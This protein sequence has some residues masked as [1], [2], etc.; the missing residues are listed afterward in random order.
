MR[1]DEIKVKFFILLACIH[2]QRFQPLVRNI[3]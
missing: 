1:T 2:S 3:F